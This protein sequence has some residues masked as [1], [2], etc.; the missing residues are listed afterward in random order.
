MIK[1][2]VSRQQKKVFTIQPI[3]I[4]P[5]EPPTFLDKWRAA[6]AG[7]TPE[8][9]AFAKGIA[10]AYLDANLEKLAAVTI[11]IDALAYDDEQ[12]V[13]QIELL[14][15]FAGDVEPEITRVFE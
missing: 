13:R 9:M 11:G 3:V 1:I 14:R 6:F 5:P 10:E 7:A 4:A 8:V 15:A 12:G 2:T